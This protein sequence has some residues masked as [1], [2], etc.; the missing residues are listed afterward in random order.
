MTSR[1]VALSKLLIG[2]LTL[3][4]AGCFPEKPVK[5]SATPAAPQPVASKTPDDI[6]ISYVQNVGVLP[7]EQAIPAG[8]LSVEPQPQIAE[9]KNAGDNETTPR[10]RTASQNSTARLKP[11]ESPATPA[12][13][14]PPVTP[15]INPPGAAAAQTAGVAAGR[16][17]LQAD[18]NGPPRDLVATKIQ[19]VRTNAKRIESAR[20]TPK[21]RTTY[22][23]VQ[24]F[25]KLADQAMSRGELRQA[26]ELADRADTLARAL[27]DGN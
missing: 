4:L 15:P 21:Q 23:R 22:R 7:P 1:T 3:V 25:I 13:T 10:R 5:V 19:G 24:S 20:L 9:H 6:P 27:T 2:T 17:P 14:A 26:N 16:S 8:A 18:D 11:A 12:A